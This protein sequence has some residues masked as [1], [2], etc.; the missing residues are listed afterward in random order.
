MSGSAVLWEYQGIAQQH[1]LAGSV[2][3]FQKPRT[4][5]LIRVGMLIYQTF[6]SSKKRQK[7]GGSARPAME[8]NQCS[9]NGQK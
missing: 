7:V 9:L 4:L 2:S 6:N 1:D 5:G 8:K 3:A